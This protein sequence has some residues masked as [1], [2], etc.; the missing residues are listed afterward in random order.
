MLRSGLETYVRAD[1]VVKPTSPAVQA[2][3]TIQLTGDGIVANHDNLAGARMQAEAQ[4]QGSGETRQ[5]VEPGKAPERLQQ[6]ARSF[7]A[8]SGQTRTGG[9]GLFF[10]GPASRANKSFNPQVC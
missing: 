5:F 1:T 3:L 4:L 8:L 7:V 10:P 9:Q 2:G 6:K